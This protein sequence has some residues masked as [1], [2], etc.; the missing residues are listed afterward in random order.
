MNHSEFELLEKWQSDPSFI[1]WVNNSNLED[2]AKWNTYFEAHPH[3][4]EIAE[5]AKFSLSINPIPIQRDKETSVKALNNLYNKIATSAKR[6]TQKTYRRFRIWQVAASFLLI[7]ACSL[8]IFS[9]NNRGKEIIVST[10]KELKEIRLTDGTAI[11]LNNNSTLKYIDNDVRSVELI[12]EAYFE[13]AKKSEPQNSFQ[14]KTK[15][16]IITVLGT[17]FNVN[18]ENEQTSVFLDEG[19]VKLKLG[20]PKQQEIEMQPGDLV[21]YSKK[22]NEVLEK[23][24]ANSLEK[25]AWKEKVILFE[26]APISKTLQTVSLIYGVKFESNLEDATDRL[27]TGGIPTNDLDITLQT[28]KDVYQ[29]DIKKIEEKYIIE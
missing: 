12:G 7:A 27:F 16:L 10:Q 11:V 28:L 17:E 23:R 9:L 6:P 24:K 19:K 5:V 1:N 20:E 3:Y 21:S 22:R 15:D 18:T 8:A 4:I 26:E 25:T 2:V 14:V 13:V 29:F